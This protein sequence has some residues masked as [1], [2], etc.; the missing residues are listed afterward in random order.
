MDRLR[1]WIVRALMRVEYRSVGR[2]KK[3]E[4]VELPPS[5][6]LVYGLCFSFVAL[7]ALVLLEALHMVFLR[8]FNEGVFA[9]ITGIIGTI[10][11]IFL[12]AK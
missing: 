8:S 5:E 3:F 1:G 12:S 11:G 4:K 2:G 7:L 6:R 9:A 10:S